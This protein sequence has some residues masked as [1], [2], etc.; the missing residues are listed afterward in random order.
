MSFGFNQLPLIIKQRYKFL[1]DL[2]DGK[3]FLRVVVG[4]VRF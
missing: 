2:I 4:V 1:Y 3:K